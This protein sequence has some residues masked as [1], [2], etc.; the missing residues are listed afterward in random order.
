MNDNDE[1]ILYVLDRAIRTEE[2]SPDGHFL[3]SVAEKVF[4]SE[5]SEV[6]GRKYVRAN[7]EVSQTCS[8]VVAFVTNSDLTFPA[9]SG[10]SRVE[11]SQVY[12]SAIR[13]M[14]LRLWAD[15]RF[16][17]VE[18][19]RL[20]FPREPVHEVPWG[21][22]LVWHDQLKADTVPDWYVDAFNSLNQTRKDCF[23]ASYSFAM[24]FT[25]LHEVG[26]FKCGHFARNSSL[27]VSQKELEADRSAIVAMFNSQHFIGLDRK[28]KNL[29]ITQMALGLVATFV[30][31]HLLLIRNS[32]AT[33]GRVKHHGYP[34]VSERASQMIRML[35]LRDKLVPEAWFGDVITVTRVLLDVASL[36][37]AFG[38]VIGTGW[39]G[40]GYNSTV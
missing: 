27:D 24:L 10:A 15:S 22:E 4:G 36:H 8:K 37:P 35:S 30:V 29:T 9:V 26:H 16:L 40:H 17:P 23:F 21:A 13:T 5:I 12:A 14:C 33:A 34:A 39:I 18:N 11:I 38:Y 28:N 31:F 6:D 2:L 3:L 19:L 25:F 20:Y 7:S 32:P 1:G